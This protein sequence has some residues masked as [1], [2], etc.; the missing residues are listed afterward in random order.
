MKPEKKPPPLELEAPVPSSVI[1]A[2]ADR[3]MSVKLQPTAIHPPRVDPMLTRLDHLPRA[4]EVLRYTVQ[5]MEHWLSPQGLLREWFRRN[6]RLALA[7]TLPLLLFA[8]AMTLLLTHAT[9]WSAQ[10]LDVAGNLAQ[11]PGKIS[12]GVMITAAGCLLLRWLMR[13]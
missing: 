13:R 10:L 8:P 5:R 12:P 2:E 1:T 4:A 6:L 3:S 7:V 9:Q 11:I